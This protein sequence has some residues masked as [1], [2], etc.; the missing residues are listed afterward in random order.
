MHLTMGAMAGLRNLYS[1]GDVAQMSVTD[2]IER[3][4]FVS[5]LFKR[6]D[7]AIQNRGDAP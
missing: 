4:G 1:H 2:A 5:L 6:V 3:M 7:K